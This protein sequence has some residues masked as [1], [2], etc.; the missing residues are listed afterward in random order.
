[1][2]LK[3]LLLVATLALTANAQ[4]A[5]TAPPPGTAS[6][7][8]CLRVDPLTGSHVQTIQCKT[9]E[10]WAALDVDVDQEWPENG[11]RILA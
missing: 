5:P 4:P 11:V 1:M 10:E 9:R 7:R 3:E 8:Y 6:T 2:A